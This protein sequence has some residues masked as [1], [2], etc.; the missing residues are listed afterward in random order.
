LFIIFNKY[1]FVIEYAA[2]KSVE[3]GDGDFLSKHE[4]VDLIRELV[5]LANFPAFEDQLLGYISELKE[6]QSAINHLDIIIGGM[7]FLISFSYKIKT[8]LNEKS[9]GECRKNWLKQ[10][11]YVGEITYGS[12][13]PLYK[14]L[15][16]TLLKVCLFEH[17]TQ[18]Y[19]TTDRS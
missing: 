2:V 4:F 18:Q 13:E 17:K 9:R 12:F 5:N 19:T 15:F 11:E 7:N 1:L 16:L 10:I 14:Q 6:V 8:D 3:N